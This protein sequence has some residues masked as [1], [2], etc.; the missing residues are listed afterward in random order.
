MDLEKPDQRT[1][2]P[3]TDTDKLYM[4]RAIE[5]AKNG[6][7]F[8]SPNPLVGCV[9]VHQGQIVGEGWHKR[10]GGPHAE[11]NAVEDVK[12]KSILRESTL[13][14]NLEPCSHTGK[15]PPCA[16]LIIRLQVRKVVIANR[17]QNPLVAGNGIRKLREAGIEVLTDVLANEGYALND[18]FFT[19]MEK[20][21]PRIILKWAETSDGFIARKNNDSKWISDEYSRQLVHKWRTEEDAVLV[22][23]GTAWHDNPSLNVRNWTGRNPVRVV[24]DRF[25]KLGPNQHVFDGSQKTLCYNLVKDEVR[26]NLTFVRLEK[27]NFLESLIRHLYSQNIQSVIVEGGGQLLNSFIKSGLWDEARIFVSPK[28]FKTGVPAPVITGVLRE[29]RQLDHDWLKILEHVP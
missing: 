1:T 17:D 11:V 4:M 14:V 9:I 16:D 23:S 12:E 7:G 15:T 3:I 18:R 22:A 19:A 21:R 28:E 27:T 5:L 2:S 13:Y 8:V 25:L 20:R 10:Y 26:E 6:R 29:A 24:I